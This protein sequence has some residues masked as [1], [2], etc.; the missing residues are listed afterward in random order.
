MTARAN[1]DA[2]PTMSDPQT[3]AQRVALVVATCRKG[4]AM[5]RAEL[6]QAKARLEKVENYLDKLSQAL[7][8]NTHSTNV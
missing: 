8:K 7:T 3:P 4:L 1:G 5:S 6:E 2:T